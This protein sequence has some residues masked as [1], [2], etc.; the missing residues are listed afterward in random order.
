MGLKL[1]KI[2]RSTLLMIVCSFAFSPFASAQDA[3][4]T[5]YEM[6][7][8]S[9]EHFRLYLETHPDHVV[10]LKGKD[11]TGMD[12]SRL[13]LRNADLSYA[14]LSNVNFKES[15]LTDA[16][17]MGSKLINTDLSRCNLSYADFDKTNATGAKF[18]DAVMKNTVTTYL[19]IQDGHQLNPAVINE[20]GIVEHATK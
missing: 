16:N 7:T 17:F 14:N 4:M 15:D 19:M 1:L 10:N 3:S 8:L 9:P 18:T 6:L 12:L 5:D 13:N 11:L 2:S 20:Q